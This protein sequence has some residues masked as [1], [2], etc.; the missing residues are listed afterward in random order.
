MFRLPLL[1]SF[2][3]IGSLLPTW[4]TPVTVTAAVVRFSRGDDCQKAIVQEIDAETKVVGQNRSIEVLMYTFT[5]RVIG[6]KL[7]AA[8]QAG[9]SVTVV[10]DASQASVKNSEYLPLK[11]ALGD[12][13]ILCHG[14][15]F[16]DGDGYG[17]MHEK[18]AI[19]GGG[20]IMEGSYNWTAAAHHYN[21]ED[22]HIFAVADPTPYQQEFDQV[23][24]Y[25][26]A[27]PTGPIRS[28]GGY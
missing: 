4:G 6:D 7:I 15:P 25:A 11:Q 10:M 20:V 21:W 8:A 28:S 12:S 17:I 24:A 27:N 19:L 3:L 9:V 1:A 5:D 26:K 18:L 13:V 16:P 22:L 14:L 23:L 2:L